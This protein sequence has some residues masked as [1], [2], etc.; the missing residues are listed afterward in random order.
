MTLDLVKP[1]FD[2]YF[3]GNAGYLLNFQEVNVVKNA[4]DHDWAVKFDIG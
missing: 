3:P 4:R 2:R 1:E